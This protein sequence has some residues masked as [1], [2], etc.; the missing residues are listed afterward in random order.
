MVYVPAKFTVDDETA[1]QTVADAG[2]GTLVISTREGLMGLFVPVIVAADRA[3]IRC[4]L[5]RANPWWRH[6]EDSMEVLGIFTAASAYVSPSYY[7]SRIE[8]PGVVP[9]W[10][11]VAA[12]VRGRL[13]L[14][15]DA[16][17]LDDQVRALT[18]RFEAPRSAT[19]SVDD[20]PPQYV[21]QQLRAIVGIGIDVVS[22]E[23]KAKLSQNRPIIDRD[24]V[25]ENLRHGTLAERNVARRMSG[26]D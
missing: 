10:N 1:W 11:Y 19:W 25:R 24:A 6:V 20:A 18:D 2:A 5:A 22:I 4:H 14:H 16:G 13:H 17:W 3:T 21:E 9:T 23:G 7:P 26:D 15:H 12:E 8:S